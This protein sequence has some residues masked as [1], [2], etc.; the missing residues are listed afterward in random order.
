MTEIREAIKVELMNDQNIIVEEHHQDIH[1]Q[2]PLFQPD[3]DHEQSGLNLCVSLPFIQKLIA[4]MVGTYFLV[5]A[6]CAAVAVNLE[7]DNTTSF[8]SSLLAI[9]LTWGIAVMVMIY[10]VGHISG[11][12]FN[13]AVTIA[14]ATC[15]TFPWNQVPGYIIAQ[16]AGSTMA[17]G[18][19]ML[20]FNGGKELKDHFVGTIPSG[21]DL[22]SLG[23]EFIT[24]FYLMFVI[25]A[26]STDNRSSKVNAGLAIGATVSANI[27]FAGPISGAS[28]NPARSLGPAIVWSRG[29]GLWI[30]MVGPTFGAI[31]GAWV[32][33]FLKLSNRSFCFTFVDKRLQT[34][35]K[36]KCK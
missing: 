33:H 8:S 29:K 25:Y 21:S 5:F 10:A 2:L 4:E 20:I 16:V 22:Q 15:N 24:T 17:S 31:A 11:A 13:P 32:Y 18:S 12:H 7:R 9:A 14:F 26:L 34:S 1:N 30:Y 36:A 6:G 3:A 28:M 27:L 19:L 35:W 23:L